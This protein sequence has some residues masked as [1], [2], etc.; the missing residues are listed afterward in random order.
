ME[1]TIV[2]NPIPAPRVTGQAL[3]SIQ[4]ADAHADRVL[5]VLRASAARLSAAISIPQAEVNA[6]ALAEGLAAL[7][8]FNAARSAVADLVVRH[9]NSTTINSCIKWPIYNKANLIP[10][11]ALQRACDRYKEELIKSGVPMSECGWATVE[12]WRDA[13]SRGC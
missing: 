2:H 5:G 8:E 12:Y 13:Q 11:E 1:I 3:R 10:D 7:E 6:A 9:R 4:M